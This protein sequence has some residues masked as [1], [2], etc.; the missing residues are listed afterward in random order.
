VYGTV[1][2]SVPLVGY[3]IHTLEQPAA[4]L[5][6]LLGSGG[7]LVLGA[8]QTIYQEVMRLSGRREVTDAD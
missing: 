4:F 8:I 2:V 1:V 3:F 5:L 7:V 6:L